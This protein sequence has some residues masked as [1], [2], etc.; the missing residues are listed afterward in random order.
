MKHYDLM[1][2]FNVRG[3]FLVTKLCVPHLRRAANPQVLTLCPPLDLAS[4]WFAPHVAYTVS[5]FGMSLMVL[6]MA[7]EYRADGIAFNALWPRT[8]IATA[9]IEYGLP[10]WQVLAGA[11][12]PGGH[13]GRCGARDPDAG[14]AQLHGPLLHRRQL[15]RRTRGRGP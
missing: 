15:S 8:P 9:A 11:C 5:K 14:G 10:G 13:R 1:Q 2:Q 6:G 3:S 4:H 7:E 12:A